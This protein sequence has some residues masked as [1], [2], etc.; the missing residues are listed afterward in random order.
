[1][2]RSLFDVAGD[3]L[4]LRVHVQPGAGRSEVVG[5]HGDALKIR[6]AAPPVSGRANDALLALLAKELAVAATALAISSGLT[7]RDKRVRVTGVD[8]DTL[9]R[10]LEVVLAGRT[11]HRRGL[12]GAAP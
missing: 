8:E 5:V 4:V 6:V 2:T 7:G 11:G 9:R 1:M 10:R 12:S 3:A